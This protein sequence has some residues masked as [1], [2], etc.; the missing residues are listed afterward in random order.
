MSQ[1]VRPRQP[2]HCR[3]A[4]RPAGTLEHVIFAGFTHEPAIG[5]AEELVRI[6]STGWERVFHADNSSSAID[7]ALSGLEL[8]VAN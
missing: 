4:G 3:G 7:T 1:A 6:A 5:L 2:A 8:V